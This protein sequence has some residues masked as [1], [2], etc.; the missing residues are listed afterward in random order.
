M[1]EKK[2]TAKVY[3]PDPTLAEIAALRE[4]IKELFGETFLESMIRTQEEFAEFQQKVN[5]RIGTQIGGR[6]GWEWRPDNRYI[7]KWKGWIDGV[8]YWLEHSILY[9]SI[10]MAFD[11]VEVVVDGF[12]T[13]YKNY[14]PQKE[15]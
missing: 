3:L 15:N 8:E 12:I 7:I 9:D 11:P 14:I 1:E 6:I 4:G 5:E 10:S 2:Y 13:A